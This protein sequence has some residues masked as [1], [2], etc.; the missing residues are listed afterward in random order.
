[1][2]DGKC[3]SA[4]LVPLVVE[5]P[6]VLTG[7]KNIP[8]WPKK[9]IPELSARV[10]EVS[11]SARRLP[12]CLAE[13][14]ICHDGGNLCR[15]DSQMTFIIGGNRVSSKTVSGRQIGAHNERRRAQPKP[16]VQRMIDAIPFWPKAIYPGDLARLLGCRINTID[17]YLLACQERALIFQDGQL[18]SRL[19]EDLSNVD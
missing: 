1:M 16:Q 18:L 2:I 19:R 17:G 11:R 4:K 5:P 14:F 8:I 15:E 12:A 13:A 7:V 9:I 6:A 10:H 3:T